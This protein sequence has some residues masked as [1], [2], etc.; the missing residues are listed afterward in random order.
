MAHKNRFWSIL[1]PSS[2]QA[3]VSPLIP[4]TTDQ[5]I[6][7]FALNAPEGELGIVNVATGGMVIGSGIAPFLAI[8]AGKTYQIVQKRDGQLEYSPKFTKSSLIKK[9]A[10]VAPVKQVWTVAAA[11]LTVAVGDE[12]EVLIIDETTPFMP[13]P[14][15]SYHHV[16]TSA[17]LNDEIGKLRTLINNKKYGPNK[18]G[19]DLVVATGSTSSIIL[20]AKYF[21]QRFKVVVRGK[22][23][24]SPTT[25]TQTTAVNFGSGSPTQV[26]VYE[27]ASDIV[28]GV[29]HA[30]HNASH[31]YSQPGDFGIPTKFTNAALTYTTFHINSE[32][33]EASPTPKQE[34]KLSSSFYLFVPV[35]GGG[36]EAL[37]TTALGL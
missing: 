12:L 13:Y 30:H 17:V 3:F 33:V 26:G 14:T 5:T 16:C 28:K 25:V 22:L 27:D 11:G 29:T 23:Q 24:G 34:H 6:R 31:G 18:D 37:L 36:P 8:E 9:Q 19:E 2:S 10:Y 4:L 7:D 20:T 1:P 32:R 15:R 21:F 35:G